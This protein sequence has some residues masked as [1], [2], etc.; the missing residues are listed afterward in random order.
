MGTPAEKIMDA[1]PAINAKKIADESETIQWYTGSLY[2][3][4]Q[5]QKMVYTVSIYVYLEC[6]LLIKGL[7][8]LGSS[9]SERLRR[10]RKEGV[11]V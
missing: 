2:G 4:Q 6:I 3:Q 7:C 10:R 11:S 5:A 1:M 8:T 9:D